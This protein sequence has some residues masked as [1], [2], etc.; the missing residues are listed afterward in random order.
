M[1]SSQTNTHIHEVNH[2]QNNKISDID[3]LSRNVIFLVNS[4]FPLT[5]TPEKVHHDSPDVLYVTMSIQNVQ[6]SS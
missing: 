6:P 5:V 1:S 4:R 3:K 2:L